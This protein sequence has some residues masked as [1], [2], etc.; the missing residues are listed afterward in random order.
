MRNVRAFL[1][2]RSINPRQSGPRENTKEN[3]RMV[4]LRRSAVLTVAARILSLAFAITLM[5]TAGSIAAIA[6]QSSSQFATGLTTPAGGLVLSGSAINPATGNPFRHL[7][8]ADA[9]NGFCRL[10]PDVDTPAAHTINPAT[11]LNTVAGGAFNAAQVTLDSATNTIYAVD[12][13]NKAGIFVLHFLPDGDTGQ[14]LMDQVNTSIL[15]PTCGLA[16]NQPN[17]TSLG[18]DGN[19]Y[20][21]FRRN[22]NI[23]R[24]ISPLTNP[25]PC[26]NVQA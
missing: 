14:G 24:I 2:S 21:G 26:A 25:L 11:C 23:M 1:S 5:L 16:V 15:A 6:Q 17:A 3:D 19:L 10:D 12:G 18:P 9:A 22:G 20:V 7:W 8:T 4:F 13:G